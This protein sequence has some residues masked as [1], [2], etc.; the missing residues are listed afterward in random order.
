MVDDLPKIDRWNSEPLDV[1]TWSDHPEIKALCDSLYEA[2]G[3]SSLEPKGNRKAKRTVKESLRVLILDLYV[4]WLK[5]PSVSIGFNKSKSSYKVGSRY[6]GLHIPE[7]VIE[8]EALLVDAGYVAELGHFHSND[9][10]LRNYTTRIRHTEALRDLFAELTIDLHDIDTHA[11]E[12]CII[13]HDRYVDDPD[14]DTVRKIEYS[15]KDLPKDELAL[16][17]TLRGQL[18]AYNKLL[19]HTLID[20]PSNTS[21]KF[22]RTITKGLNAGRQQT[23]SL[24]PDNKFVVRVF[25]EGLKGHWKSGGRFYR[26]WWQQIDK[27]DR[28]KIYIN[29]Q[30]TLEVDF[31][32]FHPNLLSN[33]LGVKLSGDPYDLGELVLPYVITTNEE[34]RE[35]IKLLVLMGINA[36][37]DKKAYKAFRNSDRK[38]KLG[39]SLTDIQLGLLLDAFIGKHPQFKGV[40]NTGQ[41]LRLMNIDSQ[42]ANMVLDYFTNKNIPVLCI[43]DS[44]IIQYDKE[45]ELR[46]ILDQA[47]H[48]VTNSIIDHDIKNVRNTHTGKVTGNIKG[49]E[50]PVVVEYHTPIRIDPTSQYLDRKTK[51]TKWIE[52]SG[53][54]LSE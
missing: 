13:L 37:N 12:E 54:Y 3:M 51:F 8:V 16:L 35:Y 33:E 41:A 47:T 43:H 22:K 34:Q 17:D 42:I 27:E 24:G 45:P 38:D 32:A 46:R 11:N 49:Y 2:A 29:D 6:N 52:L 40:L 14:D 44:F 53:N 19:K 15:D 25:N 18:T 36:D 23:I 39:Q 4:K 21:S 30:P 31:K 20:I 50:E 9:R 26:G 7:K 10:Q 5:D 48:Q 28:C 1:H